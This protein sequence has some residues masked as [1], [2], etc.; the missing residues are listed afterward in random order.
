VLSDHFQPLDDADLFNLVAPYMEGVE[1]TVLSQEAHVTHYRCIFEDGL[2]LRGEKHLTGL[3][4]TNSEVGFRA[5][6]I[7]AMIYRPACKNVLPALSGGKRIEDG[8]DAYLD[9]DEDQAYRGRRTKSIKHMGSLERIKGRVLAMIEETRYSTE[10]VTAKLKAAIIKEIGLPVEWLTAYAERE[11]I[12]PSTLKTILR[13]YEQ[14]PIPNLYGAVNATTRA[15][16][17]FS[18]FKGFDS[19]TEQRYQLELTAAEM[20]DKGLKA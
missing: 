4:I 18:D 9:E 12:A 17:E 13:A 2:E 7:Q 5:V 11:K 1:V 15:A 6:T 10:L 19:P 3:L 16:Q 8:Q 14:E 20:L